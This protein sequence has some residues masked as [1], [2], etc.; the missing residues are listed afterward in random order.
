VGGSL[1]QSGTLAK[2][3]GCSIDSARGASAPTIN[4]ATIDPDTIFVGSPSQATQRADYD[5]VSS[6]GH[7]TLTLWMHFDTTQKVCDVRARGLASP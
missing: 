3:R 7:A 6:A 2:V 1:D 5:V 4:Y